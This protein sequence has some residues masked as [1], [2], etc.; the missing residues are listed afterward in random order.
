M[1]SLF[2]GILFLC[3]A[4]GLVDL[5]LLSNYIENEVL[6]DPYARI[7][8]G[9]LGA[10]IILF[11]L[12]YLQAIF[13]CSSRERVI[14]FSS[15]QGSVSITIFAIEDMLKKIL[16]SKKELSHIRPKVLMRK[17]SVNVI[18]RSNLTSE[19][20]IVEFTKHIQEMV[21]SKLYSLFGEDKEIEVRLEIRKITLDL[22]EKTKEEKEL[23]VPFRHY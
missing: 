19:V 3:L 9:S 8:L 17:K 7:V 16:E 2:T 6:V 23:E 13:V 12:R 1:V 20:N 18:I 11:C 4:L 10:L 14:T 21:R 22:K 15:S 5:T